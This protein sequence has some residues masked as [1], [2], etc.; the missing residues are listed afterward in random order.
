MPRPLGCYERLY[1]LKSELSEGRWYLRLPSGERVIWDDGAAKDFETQLARPDVQDQFA[2]PYKTGPQRREP[3][4]DHDPGRVR[5]TAILAAIFPVQV[6]K[7]EQLTWVSWFG[8]RLHVHRLIAPALERV[9][10]RI[11]AAI[12]KNPSLRPWLDR[13]GGAYV[14]RPIA[15]TDRLSA[16]SFGIAIDIDPK[17]CEYWRWDHNLQGNSQKPFLRPIPAALVE[18]FESEG[19]I[20][21]GRWYHYDTMHF[22]YRPEL[23]DPACQP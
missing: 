16:H 11:E 5:V 17:R 3:G 6:D 19:F 2:V 20:W 18:A 4:I 15:G 13:P 23:L 21:G 1:G 14:Y 8:T 7:I 12:A 9:R 22:E 10:G